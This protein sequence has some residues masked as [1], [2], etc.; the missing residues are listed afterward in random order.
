M[1]MSS[2]RYLERGLC[3]LSLDI[4]ICIQTFIEPLDVMSLR[5]TCK[6]LCDVTYQRSVW[7]HVARRVCVSR[8]LFLPS[9]PLEIMSRRALEHVAL[10]SSSYRFCRMLIEMDADKPLIPGSIHILD[11]R[12]AS[13]TNPPRQS[14]ELYLIPGGRYL[15]TRS[16]TAINLWDLGIDIAGRMRPLPVAALQSSAVEVYNPRP[17]DDGLGILLFVATV[18]DAGMTCGISVYSIYPST[19]NPVFLL[20][21]SLGGFNVTMGVWSSN[22]TRLAFLHSGRRILTI[23]DFKHNSILSWDNH[24]AEVFDIL[25]FEDHVILFESRR[26]SLYKVPPLRPR[27]SEGGLGDVLA[28]GH[29]LMDFAYPS[30]DYCARLAVHW[31]PWTPLL[32]NYLFFGVVVDDAIGGGGSINYYIMKPLDDPDLPKMI[33]LLLACLA[34]DYRLRLSTSS[35]LHLCGQYLSQSWFDPMYGVQIKLSTI[36]TK[37]VASGGTGGDFDRTIK[38]WAPGHNGDVV[39]DCSICPATGRLCLM[40]HDQEIRVIDFLTP[41]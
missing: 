6:Y 37:T 27:K 36:P 20:L 25:I 16:D 31:N 17:T 7:L 38:L 24:N 12:C 15:I 35:T 9:F 14:R 28:Q 26:F 22:D 1:K 30:T 29:S 40:T 5:K 8:G 18:N 33:P 2:D 10:S 39:R 32:N 13:F 41:L 21:T 19:P 23:W 34:T 3:K 11:S 4:Q